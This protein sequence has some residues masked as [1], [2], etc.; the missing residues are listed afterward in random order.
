MRVLMVVALICAPLVAR[1]DEELDI[2]GLDATDLRGDALIWE[3]ATIYLEPWESGSTVKFGVISR[4]RDEVGRAMPVRIVDSTM[5]NFVEIAPVNRGDC[6]WRRLEIDN[7]LDGLRMFVRREDL[8]PVLIK[9]YAMQWSHGTKLKL[10]VGMPVTPTM[11]GD[12]LVALRNDKIRVGIPHASVGYIYKSSKITDPELPKEKVARIDRGANVK[13]GED[14]F[15]VRSNWY[16]PMPEKKTDVALIRLATRCVEMTVS[17]PSNSL[18]LMEVPRQYTPSPSIPSVIAGWRIPSGTPLTTVGG[19]EVAVAA[20]EITVS[21]PIAG[22]DQTCFD[23]K[24]T[25]VKEDESYGS[26]PRTVKLCASGAAVI[27]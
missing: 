14:G 11:T 4:R 1:A 20:K 12:Y 13:L 10:A 7:R 16:G 27:K 15:S 21:M 9:P 2:P 19:R 3:D 26:V 23:A 6:S 22:Q 25:M 8:A 17:A 5:K 18:R 24:V